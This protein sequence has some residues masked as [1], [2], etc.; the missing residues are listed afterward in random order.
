MTGRGGWPVAALLASALAVLIAANAVAGIV[1][2]DL[3]SALIVDMADEFSAP[4]ASRYRATMV[5]MTEVLLFMG[6]L[7]A[8]VEAVVLAVLAFALL[9]S[10]GWARIAGMV[11]ASIGLLT[12]V[13][14]A[15]AYL[16][17]DPELL[18]PFPLFAWLSQRDGVLA[19]VVATAAAALAC[20]GMLVDLVGFHRRLPE[21]RT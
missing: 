15:V 3:V 8:L 5:G 14:T 2:E 13:P 4:G 11:A 9:A 17:I 21:A 1:F 6:W 20:L 19:T 18:L 16:L 12:F 7:A 10:R